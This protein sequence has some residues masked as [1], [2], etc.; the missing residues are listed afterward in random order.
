[1]LIDI[2]IKGSSVTKEKPEY[3]NIDVNDK[4]AKIEKNEETDEI[5]DGGEGWFSEEV[6]KYLRELY[7]WGG[8][9]K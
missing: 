7:R 9:T 1:M 4:Y 6:T 2:G 3:R 5:V 8:T